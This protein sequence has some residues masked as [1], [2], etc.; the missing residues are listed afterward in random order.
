MF[1]MYNSEAKY[2]KRNHRIYTVY[3]MYKLMVY[4]TKNTLNISSRLTSVYTDIALKLLFDR[5]FVYR[6][7][8]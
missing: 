6:I 8:W 3:T 7:E 1:Y 4:N 5:F 2:T